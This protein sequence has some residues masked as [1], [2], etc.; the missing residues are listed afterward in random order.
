[1]K[2]LYLLLPVSLLAACSTPT[3]DSAREAWHWEATRPA[4]RASLPA[5]ELAQLTNRIAALSMQRSQ[6]RGRISAEPDIAARQRLYAQL[7]DVGLQLSP[8]ERQLAAAASAR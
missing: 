2:S 6:I 4:V 8:L 5:A 3:I 7:H 1:M